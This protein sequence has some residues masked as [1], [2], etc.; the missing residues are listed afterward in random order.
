MPSSKEDVFLNKAVS[1]IDKRKLMKFLTFAMEY[2]LNDTLLEGAQDMTYIQLLQEKFKITGKLQ[3]AIVYAIAMVDDKTSAE[4]GLERTH[5]FVKAMGRFG[6]GAYLCPLYGG[7]SEIAQAF[8]RVCA[9]YGGVYIL[10]QSLENF[11]IGQEDNEVH[12]IVTKEGQEY[13]CQKL[14]TGIDYLNASWLPQ[15]KEL[16]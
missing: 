14:I 12:G 16:G 7:G 11:I 4:I 13:K 15:E 9:V 3:E 6:K 2:D 5:Q 10:N 8:C 1:L